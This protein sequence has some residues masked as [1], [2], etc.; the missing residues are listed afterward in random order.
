MDE[1]QRPGSP[2]QRAVKRVCVCVCVRARA[3]SCVLLQNA[4]NL[5]TFLHYWLNVSIKLQYTHTHPYLPQRLSSAN[6]QISH[7]FV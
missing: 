6:S 2:G 7:S 3:N 4:M 1:Q 5:A